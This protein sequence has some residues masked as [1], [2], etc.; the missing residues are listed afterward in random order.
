[1]KPLHRNGTKFAKLRAPLCQHVIRVYLQSHGCNLNMS[2]KT[3][4]F[5]NIMK[6]KIVQKYLIIR[7]KL[8]HYTYY[9]IKRKL[10]R[11]VHVS[12]L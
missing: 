4:I 1:M 10:L 8:F 2:E 5:Q 3:N 11:N 9:L 12:R 7:K 6:Y